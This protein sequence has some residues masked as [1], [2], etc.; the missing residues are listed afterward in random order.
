ME[1]V[2]SNSIDTMEVGLFRK[3]AVLLYC[4]PAEPNQESVNNAMAKL[5]A[6]LGS[7]MVITTRYKLTANILWLTCVINLL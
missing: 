4:H 5:L 6:D 7:N 2:K 1:Y 3:F